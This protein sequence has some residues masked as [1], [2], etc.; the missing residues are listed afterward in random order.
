VTVGI[1]ELGSCVL[2]VDGI[3]FS[4]WTEYSFSS[5]FLVPSDGGRFVLADENVTQDLFSSIIPGRKYQLLINGKPQ[6]TGYIEVVDFDGDRTSGNHIVV[7]VRDTMGPVVDA[8]I[9]PRTHFPDKTTLSKL[10]ED[11]LEPFGF[12]TFFID[13]ENNSNIR[14]GK[15]LRRPKKSKKKLA[16]Y[17]I[18]KSKPHHNERYFDF[19][20][21]IV[22]REG[23]WIWPTVEGNGVVVS[24][25]DYDQAPRYQIR[26]RIGAAGNNVLR[27]GIRRDAVDQPSYIVAR[28]NIPPTEFEHHK[29]AVVY[30]SPYF[31]ID[32]IVQG[33]TSNI[34][35]FRPIGLNTANS[36]PTETLTFSSAAVRAH[37]EL[38]K[39]TESIPAQPIKLENSFASIVARPKYRTDTESKSK[40]QL[41]HYV[42]REMSLYVRRACSGR[43]LV[44]GH[45]LDGQPLQ[46]D[47]VVDVQDDRS[48]W[49]QPMWILSVSHRK[50]RHGGT[51][52]EIETLPLGAIII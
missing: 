8:E 18:P 25:P 33:S 40:A 42:K 37:Q 4:V 16:E 43:Y 32:Q 51:T 21:R 5:H 45:E 28:G 13:N 14:A 3:E 38:F 50:S 26:R 10:I 34:P 24:V 44:L 46:V 15:A 23:L 41:S 49:H 22:Q 30:D 9:D 48:N 12:D 7:E 11:T 27:G 1:G 31:G 19:L 17:P 52:T 6:A 39:W 36:N 47:T 2:L 20:S 29:M 35:P